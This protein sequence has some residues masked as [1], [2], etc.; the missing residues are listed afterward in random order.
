VEQDNRDKPGNKA[1]LEVK[2]L[3]DYKD[4]LENKV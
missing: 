1:L 3:L 2:E 4:L